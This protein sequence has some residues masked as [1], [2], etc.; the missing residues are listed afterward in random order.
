MPFPLLTLQ[1]VWPPSSVGSNKSSG[2][3]FYKILVC[4][5]YAS[6]TFVVHAHYVQLLQFGL[7]IDS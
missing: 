5:T 3:V 6:G 7:F 2:A 1:A 4:I